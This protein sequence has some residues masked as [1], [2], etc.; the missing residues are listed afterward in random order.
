MKFSWHS[1][2][3]T[4]SFLVVASGCE[5]SR[6]RDFPN[7]AF[8][9]YVYLNNPAS[10]PLQSVGGTIF[11]GGGYSGLIVHRRYANNTSDDFAAYDRGCP[12][13]Y[14]QNC[15]RLEISDDG[16][17]AECPCEGEKYLIF[18]GAPGEGAQLSLVPYRSTFDGSVIFIRN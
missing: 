7:V 14:A 15:G 11:H 6:N 4:C 2:L 10:L 16:V 13:H 18:D 5:N 12:E 8:Q 3:L 9:E 17:F 1:I